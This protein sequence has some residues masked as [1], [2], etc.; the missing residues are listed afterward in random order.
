MIKTI[1]CYLHDSCIF[2]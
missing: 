2:V 1:K